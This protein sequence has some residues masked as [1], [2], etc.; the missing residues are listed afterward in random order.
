[1][2]ETFDERLPRYDRVNAARAVDAL[3]L[4]QT[5]AF[6]AQTDQTDDDPT[7]LQL[8]ETLLAFSDHAGF[9]IA[10]R[11]LGSLD[12]MPLSTTYHLAIDPRLSLDFEWGV[13]PAPCPPRGGH[14]QRPQRTVVQHPPDLAPPGW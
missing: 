5:A 6:E 14:S 3:R 9:A 8:T 13:H 4:A 12:E 1:M 2:L 7:H 11:Q 10:N